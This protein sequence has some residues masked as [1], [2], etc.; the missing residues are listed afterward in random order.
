MNAVTKFNRNGLHI[1]VLRG[2]LEVT[3]VLFK[4][5]IDANAY[6]ND[7]NTALHFAAE[8]GYK[9]LINFLLEK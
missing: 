9:E 1:A 8:N 3:K 4:F 7:G 6:D 2:H 5:N